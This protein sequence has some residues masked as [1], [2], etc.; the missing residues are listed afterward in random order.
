MGQGWGMNRFALS[1]RVFSAL[2][3]ICCP[4]VRAA[5]VDQDG[6]SDFFDLCSNTPK[7]IA[8]NSAGQPLADAD[9]DCDVDLQDFALL[10]IAF[11]SL[12]DPAAIVANMT[13]P[14]PCVVPAVANDIELRAVV[15]TRAGEDAQTCVLPSADL[16][17]FMRGCLTVE[18]FALDTSV[19]QQGIT[20]VFFDLWTVGAECSLAVL[21]IQVEKVLSEFRSGE[22]A[23]FGVDEVGGCAINE[24]IGLNTWTRV[25]T[26]DLLTPLRQCRTEIT[27]AQADTP[28]SLSGGG[29]TASIGF[30]DVGEIA[31]RCSGA[32][33]DFDGSG[34]INAADLSRLLPCVGQTAPFSSSCQGMDFNCDGT[35]DDNDR[36]LFQ[37]A[38]QKAICGGGIVLPACQLHC[39]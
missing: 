37:S 16:E 19:Q 33:Y 26:I 21:G 6:I 22:L 39:Q 27:L 1:S 9:D 20:C 18:V 5:D 38:W 12:E 34:Q 8:I 13:G 17:H 24:T 11:H 14:L 23:P 29:V 35:I 30:E 7:G 10:Q 31:V 36:I 2:A 28:S 4:S 25:A 32:L 15:R 3:L